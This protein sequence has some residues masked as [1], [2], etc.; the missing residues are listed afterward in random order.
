MVARLRRGRRNRA[1]RF[2]A[3]PLRRPTR[4]GSRNSTVFSG[5]HQSDRHP[6]RLGRARVRRGE[7][8]PGQGLRLAHRYDAGRVRRSA[9]PGAQ[10]LGPR[11]AGMALDPVSR[12]EPYVYVLYA[13]DAA[14]GGTAPRWGTAG[15]TSDGCPTPPGATA[16]GCVVSG[17]LSRLTAS[18]N[19]MTGPEQVLI[20]D[21]CQQYPSHSIGS[22]DFGPDGALY[23]TGGDGASFNFVDY[24]Q[25][26]SPLNPCGDPPGGVGAA[27]TPPTAEGGALRSQDLRTFGRS[28]EPRRRAAARRPRDRRRASRQPD[29]ASSTPTRGA[30][31]P[32]A[33]A[34]RSGIAVRPGT[35]E[36]WIGDVG[37]NTWEE[38]NR[39]Q[40]RP[41]RVDEL[42]LALL[43]GRP[44]RAER[45]RLGQPLDLREPLRRRPAPCRRRCSRGT[46]APR[47]CRAK[48]CPTGSSSAAGIAFAPTSGTY[49][50]DTAARCS[51]PTTRAT[52][53]GRCCLARTAFPIRPGSARSR[54]V[55][56]TR[57]TSRSGPAAICST[58]TSTAAPSAACASPRPTSHRRRWPTATPT[59]GPAPLTVQFDG[60]GSTDPDPGDT[61]TYAWD[62]DGDG[63]YDDS[64]AVAPSYTYTSQG[65]YTASLR[66]TD[67]SGAIEHRGRDD[68]RRQHAADRDDHRPGRRHAVVGRQRD[69]VRRKRQRRPG[70]SPAR[71]EPVVGADPAPLP[72]E[73]PHPPVAEL[74]GRRRRLVHRP[75][76][77]IPRLPRAATHS[78]GLRR[79][80]RYRVAAT[81]P[82]HGRADAQHEPLRV[83]P[84]STARCS[85][86]PSRGR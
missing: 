26:G 6:F 44:A 81:R 32:T 31:S 65:V 64:T 25:D 10:L 20:E 56:R 18:G 41:P 43:R 34:T 85:R 16:D 45:L 69:P 52:A 74:R 30:S 37:W 33:C 49:P 36:V 84:G 76:P 62:L 78:D 24:G 22:L 75:R 51:S 13:Y 54:P 47:S 73:L 83:Q 19:S 57:S 23:V 48:T 67:R 11:T 68:R 38:I 72:V 7:E 14:I 80:G 55:L 40:S 5:P 58:P 4:R 77:R 3:P 63:E 60:S 66:V 29:S 35:G 15:A 39:I 9:D 27:L 1:H 61:L 46:T 17:R 42:R 59:T 82:A 21:W 8:R 86:R 53:S 2:P 71:L 70:R 79:P 50:T 28:D 12:T